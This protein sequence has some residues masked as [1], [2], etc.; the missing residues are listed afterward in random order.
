MYFAVCESWTRCLIAGVW[1]AKFGSFWSSTIHQHPINQFQNLDYHNYSDTSPEIESSSN[2]GPEGCQR[3]LWSNFVLQHPLPVKMHMHFKK[4]SGDLFS[5]RKSGHWRHIPWGLVTEKTVM[6]FI[7]MAR[8]I[9]VI[10]VIMVR[11]C[12]PGSVGDLKYKLHTN[13]VF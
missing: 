12:R 1:G 10:E 6:M 2:L 7:R 11:T 4:V 8:Y 5:F 9:F 3:Y 13:E